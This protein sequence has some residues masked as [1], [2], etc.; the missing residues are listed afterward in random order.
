[1]AKKKIKAAKAIEVEQTQSINWKQPLIIATISATINS[2]NLT[3]LLSKA[4]EFVKF[5]LL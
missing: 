4:W 5:I 3:L 1:M 2:E